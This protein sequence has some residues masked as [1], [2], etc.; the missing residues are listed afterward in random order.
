[1]TVKLTVEQR[2][3]VVDLLEQHRKVAEALSKIGNK[4]WEAAVTLVKDATNEMVEVGVM[5]GFARAA[6]EEQEK[7]VVARLAKLGI[8]M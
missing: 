3:Q 1:M 5:P 8:M 7:Y 2:E 4:G 6:L